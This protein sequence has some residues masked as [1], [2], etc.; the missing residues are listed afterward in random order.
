MESVIKDL[1]AD[2]SSVFISG[3][4][5]VYPQYY[6]HLLEVRERIELYF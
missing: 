5:L 6:V 1:E 4:L 3:F 2:Y